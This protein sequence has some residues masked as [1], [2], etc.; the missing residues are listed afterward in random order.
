MTQSAYCHNASRAIHKKVIDIEIV[1]WTTKA[2]FSR[3]AIRQNG[4]TR[5]TDVEFRQSC[6]I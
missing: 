3:P 2:V 1:Q 4:H 5:V 6:V